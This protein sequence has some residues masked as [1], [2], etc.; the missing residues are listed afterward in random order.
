MKNIPEEI[1]SIVF[2]LIER[3]DFSMLSAEQKETILKYISEE[4]YVEFRHAIKAIQNNAEK[5]M[6]TKHF[7]LQ[8][9]D[10][11]YNKETAKVRALPV[12]RNLLRVA[13]AVFF[14]FSGWSGYHFIRLGK[15]TNNELLSTIDTVFVTKEIAALPEKIY[16]TIYIEKDRIGENK[17]NTTNIYKT[18]SDLPRESFSIDQQAGVVSIKELENNIN[19]PRRNSLKDDT[20]AKKFGFV[21]L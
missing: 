10:Q 3:F 4:E 19:M 14:F 17:S 5:N 2:D 16:D 21:T 13:A 15:T 11:Y 6:S 20:L 9:Y 7:L 12:Y 1:P 8:N 18:S